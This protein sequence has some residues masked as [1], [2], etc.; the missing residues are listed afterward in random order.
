MG[1]VLKILYILLFSNCVFADFFAYDLN[2]LYSK[3]DF[4]FIHRIMPFPNVAINDKE[5][6]GVNALGQVYIYEVSNQGEVPQDC[7]ASVIDLL[8]KIGLL[9]EGKIKNVQFFKAYLC[10]RVCFWPTHKIPE[11]YS[12]FTQFW[13][14]QNM[15]SPFPQSVT[16]SSGIFEPENLIDIDQE[17]GINDLVEQKMPFDAKGTLCENVRF[18]KIDNNVEK[19]T[20]GWFVSVYDPEKNLKNLSLYGDSYLDAQMKQGKRA[21]VVFFSFVEPSWEINF[22]RSKIEINLSLEP[23]I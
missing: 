15:A 19:D 22:L 9:F 13:A 23:Q 12:Y 2:A 6:K 3:D 11:S 18:K 20:S 21:I 5:I 4:R 17:I 14:I 7:P 10:H 8:S 16:I 1:H